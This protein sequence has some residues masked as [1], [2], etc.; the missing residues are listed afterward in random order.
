MSAFFGDIVQFFTL[1]NFT[2]V[3]YVL[4]FLIAIII[5]FFD[6]KSP[7]ASIAWIMILYL[8]PL[9]GLI[10]YLLFSQH[11]AGMKIYKLSEEEKWVKE[12]LIKYQKNKLLTDV[13][14]SPNRIVHKWR[15]LVTLNLEYSNAALTDNKSV[16]LISDGQEKFD[17][18]FK[19]IQNAKNRIHICYFIIK[20]DFLGNQLIDLLTQKAAEGVQV[21][22][23][24]D[25]MGSKQISNK[26][27]KS[28][29]EAGG[30]YSF[31]FKPRIRKLYIRFNY[32]NHRK[33]VIIDDKIGYI[34]GFN[35]AREYVGQ[36]AKFGY[37]R[38]AHIRIIGN[39]VIPLN[40][41]F[42]TDWRCSTKEPINLI[43]ESLPERLYP[44]IDGKIPIQI[45]NSGPE[46][47]KEEI[48]IAMMKMISG[49]KKTIHIQTPYLVPDDSLIDALRMAIRAGV[50]VKIMI[51]CRP[52]HPFVYRTTLLNAGELI[53]EGARIFIYEDGFLHAKT[54]SVD[55]EVATIGSA[56]FDIRSFR[57]NFESN[58]II[59]DNNFA[60]EM[61]RQFENDVALHCKEYTAVDRANISLYEYVAER[62]SRLLKE[63]L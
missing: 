63:I 31:F 61:D 15:D 12:F 14:H 30:N 36:K 33:I 48:K 3:I 26:K 9:V 19:D 59:Y 18:L 50:D 57:L 20:D 45:V 56:N 16:Q 42:L 28:F 5:I 10:G 47:P 54:L 53:N 38:D 35:V 25:A 58:A 43:K 24:M 27:L 39:A 46:S 23:L 52:D 62:I 51:P 55:G 2:T 1:N 34:G 49:A 7:G 17:L 8:L 6:R 22:L 44:E 60:K 40:S 11:I 21:R 41:I 4:N 32:R 29:K 13:F 37:W